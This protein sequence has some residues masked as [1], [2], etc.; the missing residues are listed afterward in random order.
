MT[1]VQ[2]HAPRGRLSSP[3]RLM[4]RPRGDDVAE[5]SAE[6]PGSSDRSGRDSRRLVHRYWAAVGS[7]TPAA[8][9]AVGICVAMGVGFTGGVVR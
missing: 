7:S 2:V 1:R 6:L 9:S 3:V 4:V 8:G 5:V